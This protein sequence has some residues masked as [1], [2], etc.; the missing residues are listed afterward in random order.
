MAQPSPGL[1]TAP[2]L[3]RLPSPEAWELRPSGAQRREP[4]L[5]PPALLR[6]QPPR[7]PDGMPAGTLHPTSL[8]RRA[9][10][11]TWPLI[12]FC[13]KVCD[14]WTLGPYDLQPCISNRN[15]PPALGSEFRASP[16]KMMKI[17]LSRLRQNPLVSVPIAESEA[18]IGTV[19]VTGS[20]QIC[21]SRDAR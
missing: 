18:T 9:S 5:Q 2:P 16:F 20:W 8:N 17:G 13:F 11:V 6:S 21:Q 12:R 14:C 15:C 7:S 19:G 3:P 10:G 4:G 1:E